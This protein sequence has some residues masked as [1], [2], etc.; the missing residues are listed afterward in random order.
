MG[1]SKGGI[2]VRVTARL[3][4]CQDG[5]KPADRFREGLGNLIPEIG[6]NQKNGRRLITTL[7]VVH[8]K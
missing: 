5:G 1:Y 3:P 2:A 6:K 4:D 8:I 7:Q